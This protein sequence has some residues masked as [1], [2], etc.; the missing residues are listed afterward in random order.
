MEYGLRRENE[1]NAECWRRNLQRGSTMNKRTV[2]GEEEK[3]LVKSLVLKN[4]R[5]V[6]ST[7]HQVEKRIAFSVEQ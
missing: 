7:I 1:M 3:K 4:S 5:I 6:E 2:F